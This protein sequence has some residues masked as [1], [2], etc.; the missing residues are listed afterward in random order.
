MPTMSVFAPVF[1]PMKLLEVHGSRPL[2][3]DDWR[4]MPMDM[5]F[6]GRNASGKTVLVKHLL[7]LMRDVWCDGQVFWLCPKYSWESNEV[8][9]SDTIHR[10]CVFYKFSVKKS[11]QLIFFRLGALSLAKQNKSQC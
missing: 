5:S 3:E 10:K 1:D 6:V 7:S 2:R 4:K 11:I 9:L 8:L